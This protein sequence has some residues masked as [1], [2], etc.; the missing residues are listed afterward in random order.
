MEVQGNVQQGE[1]STRKRWGRRVVWGNFVSSWS[2]IKD[3]RGGIGRRGG[4]SFRSI[5]RSWLSREVAGI[6]YTRSV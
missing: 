1:K 3:E 2:D 5:K 6:V 4:D